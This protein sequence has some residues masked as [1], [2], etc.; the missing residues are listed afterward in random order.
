MEEVIA[1]DNDAGIIHP[2]LA[3]RATRNESGCRTVEAIPGMLIHLT[4]QEDLTNEDQHVEAQH[5]SRVE[6]RNASPWRS[7]MC[8]NKGEQLESERKHNNAVHC[9]IWKELTKMHEGNGMHHATGM[10]CQVKHAR[11]DELQTTF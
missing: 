10:P 4:G 1:I 9:E 7:E 6:G 11:D 3:S 8:L 5:E 2:H